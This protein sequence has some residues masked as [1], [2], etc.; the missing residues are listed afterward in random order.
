M[1]GQ[2]SYLDDADRYVRSVHRGWEGLKNECID[3]FGNV[4]GVCRGSGYSYS[5]LYYKNE[6][7]WQLNDTHGIGIVLLA[8]IEA[9][10]LREF[11][12]SQTT[13]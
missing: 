10:R 6:L 3:K 2:S 9:L 1:T 12:S 13:Q 4:Y 5:A 7:T 11:F 8:G